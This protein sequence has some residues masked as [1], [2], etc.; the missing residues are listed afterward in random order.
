M[1]S[2][3]TL[4]FLLAVAAQN[5]PAEP[6]RNVDAFRLHDFRGASFSLDVVRDRKLVVL[7]F[8]GVECPLANQYAPRL[9]ELARAFEPKGVAFVAIDANQ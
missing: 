1:P 2:F 6:P 3:G 8:L 7:A 4:L 5:A 9:V